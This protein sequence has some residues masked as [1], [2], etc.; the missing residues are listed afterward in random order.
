L[1]LLLTLIAKKNKNIYVYV[2]AEDGVEINVG[3]I[4]KA[5]QGD[6]YS[7]WSIGYLYHDKKEY[8]KALAWYRLS[9]DKNHSYSQYH[10]GVMYHNEEGVPANYLLAM[11]WFIKAARQHHKQACS[12]I[13]DLFEKGQGVPVNKYKALEW[14]CKVRKNAAGVTTLNK[15]GFHII[16]QD[17]SKFFF[18]LNMK[19]KHTN[20]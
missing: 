12:S 7:L 11:E 14:Y 1:L 3:T 17:E 19:N 18:F 2:Q 5:K 15:Q 10:I 13:G 16:K 20:K 9:A 4:N 6:G 8:D